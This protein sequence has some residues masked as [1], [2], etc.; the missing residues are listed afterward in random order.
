MSLRRLKPKLHHSNPKSTLYRSVDLSEK[1]TLSKQKYDHK[2]S[3]IDGKPLGFYFDSRF[4][5]KTI[6]ETINQYL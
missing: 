5:K 3:G 4:R 6:V 2:I 1:A